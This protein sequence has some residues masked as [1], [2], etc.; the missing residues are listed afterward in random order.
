MDAH[1]FLPMRCARF[2]IAV[3]DRLFVGNVDMH[4]QPADRRRDLFAKRVIDVEDR[5]LHPR[6]CE[7]LGGCAAE[8]RRAA[9]DHGR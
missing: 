8:A 2:R 4:E 3:E 9:G 1:A 6:G 5:D 7:S